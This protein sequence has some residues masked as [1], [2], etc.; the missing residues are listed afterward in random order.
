MLTP[1]QSEVFDQIKGLLGEHFDAYV[2]IV[3]TEVE[4][5]DDGEMATFWR[6][7]HQWHSASVGLLEK[8]K[9]EM[10]GDGRKE[11]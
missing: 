1:K 11:D 10:L 3:E 4:H 5:P 7:A 9:A 6:G 2:L 8:Y